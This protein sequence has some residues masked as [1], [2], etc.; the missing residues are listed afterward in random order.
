MSAV[1]MATPRFAAGRYW[2]VRLLSVV[3]A[4]GGAYAFQAFLVPR[5]NSYDVRLLVLALLYGILAVSLN[6][7]NGITGQFSI[8]HAAF[9]MVGAYTAG[10]ITEPWGAAHQYPTSPGLWLLLMVLAG[11]ASAAIAGFVVGL[12]SLR[13]KGDYLAIVTLGFGEIARI[14]VNNQDGSDQA[15]AHLNLGGSYRLDT[16]VHLTELFHVAL[17]FMLAVAIGRNVLKTAHG[18]SFLS[19]REDELAASAVG[20]NTTKT[21]V[22]A[23]VL[24]AALAGMAGA[25]F[26]LFNRTVSPDDFRM[27]VS[28]LVVA[29]VVIGGTGS[30]TGAALAAIGLKLFEEGLR[31]FGSIPAVT[32]FAYLIAIVLV[33]ILSFKGKDV[34]SVPAVQAVLRVVGFIGCVAL[35][36]A[37]WL[38]YRAGI[39]PVIKAAFI[40]SALA[41]V[42]AF[43][44]T[45]ARKSLPKFGSFLAYLVIIG[46][47]H[48]PIA[49][50]L[51]A[52]PFIENQYNIPG[53][54]ITYTPSDLRWAVYALSLVV[55]MLLRPQGLMG[56]HEFSWSSIKRM[57]GMPA[58]QTEVA[59]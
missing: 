32:L 50:L 28:F 23:F 54:P 46:I 53:N 8:G 52:I 49:M 40:V 7:I 5:L 24:G 36:Y 57:F 15:I 55:V 2:I 26:A 38:C 56:H 20:I 21:K 33:T 19:V 1:P 59:A 48:F 17:L 27:D 41:T 43:L 34:M 4:I 12:P 35:L 16:H 51:H 14:V 3:V 6:F 39:S 18:L 31:N 37:A 44:F 11:G 42:V 22:T 58:P 10:K 13:L 30:I 29:M 25:M 45:A 9:Y 47:L